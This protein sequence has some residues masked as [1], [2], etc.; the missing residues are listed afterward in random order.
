MRKCIDEATYLRHLLLRDQKLDGNRALTV[1][2][3]LLTTDETAR[4]HGRV[5]TIGET[6][7]DLLRQTDSLT[8]VGINVLCHG[9]TSVGFNGRLRRAFP[10]LLKA[11]RLWLE[12]KGAESVIAVEPQPGAQTAQAAPPVVPAPAN[13]N[14]ARARLERLVMTNYRL[15]GVRELILNDARVHL[16][17]GPNGSGK[18]S[19]AEA[20]ELM[21]S[22]KVDR[23]EK[24]NERAYDRVIWNRTTK[25]AATIKLQW[26]ADANGR[27]PDSV[28]GTVTQTGL[29]VP[30]NDKVHASSFRLDQA[31]MDRLVAHVP[32]ERARV[33]LQAFFPEAGPS[34]VEYQTT[35]KRF[36]TT[37]DPI[38]RRTKQLS[39]ARA[40]LKDLESW[41]GGTS[42]PTTEDHHE[43]LNRWLEL[44]ALVDLAQRERSLRLRSRRAGVQAGNRAIPCR[45]R[46]P[47]RLAPIP[48]SRNSK[49][50]SATALTRS[51]I[52]TASC[53]RSRRRPTSQPRQDR[54]VCQHPGARR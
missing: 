18:S 45:R 22:G 38:Q 28:L 23:I 49:R 46:S 7:R 5:A 50:R 26:R 1:E 20:L 27:A 39:E 47:R 37:R 21:S 48:I 25:E 43:L 42:T 35:A 29:D 52:C 36:Q 41:R 8:H 11:T 24:A 3:V 15:P 10:W 2:L 14:G 51:A 33:F 31:L 34:L 32:H 12:S 9:G 30:L 53:R 6:L 54:C 17:H 19:I 40:A 4:D 13:G 16:I 44:T